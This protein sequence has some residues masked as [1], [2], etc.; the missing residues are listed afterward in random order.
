MDKKNAFLRVLIYVS[1]FLLATT[2]AWDIINLSS[3]D[4][5]V[6]WLYVWNYVSLFY[7]FSKEMQ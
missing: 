6:Q 1:F 4:V 5:D 2:A 3:A 7:S